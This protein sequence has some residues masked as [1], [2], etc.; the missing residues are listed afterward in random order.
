M[1]NFAGLQG[2]AGVF[3]LLIR[4]MAHKLHCPSPHRSKPKTDFDKNIQ[5]SCHRVSGAVVLLR[6][7]WQPKRIPRMERKHQSRP[8]G[9][10]PLLRHRKPY[11][12]LTDQRRD[13]YRG[14]TV[15]TPGRPDI[16]FCGLRVRQR[17]GA[18]DS[19]QRGL[20]RCA[21][22]FNRLNKYERLLGHPGKRHCDSGERPGRKHGLYLRHQS[23]H[24]QQREF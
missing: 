6:G 22:E 18:G 8:S 14:H 23:Q 15:R 5:N 1:Q 12:W 11:V 3:Q 13:E 20:I 10:F 7:S 21:D 16:L 19:F 17:G 2:V 4:S 9:L 24:G